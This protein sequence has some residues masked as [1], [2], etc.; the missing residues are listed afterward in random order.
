MRFSKD[1]LDTQFLKITFILASLFIKMMKLLTNMFFKE[2]IYLKKNR[3][4]VEIL[5]NILLL[6]MK[7]SKL[8]NH[9]IDMC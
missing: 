9:L 8:I 1:S 2:K 5:K 6:T 3:K 4:Y 7:I